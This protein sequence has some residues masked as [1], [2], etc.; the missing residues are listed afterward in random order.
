MERYTFQIFD[1]ESEAQ[2]AFELRHQVFVVE[3]NI[4]TYLDRDQDDLISYHLIAYRDH[5]P[6]GTGR[7]T[8]KQEKAILARIAVMATERGQGL[9]TQILEKLEAL[10][11]SKNANTAQLRPH[12]YLQAFYEKRGYHLISNEVEVIANVQL[13]TMAKNLK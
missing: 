2:E 1:K 12:A 10:G 8:L 9:A 6:V 5:L 13:V 3:Q 11:K 7:L 4:P